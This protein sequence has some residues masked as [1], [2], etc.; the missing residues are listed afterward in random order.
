MT[1]AD[2]SPH[3][4]DLRVGA[5]IRSRR[6]A[7]GITQQGLAAALGISFQQIQKYETGL[8]RISASRL[9]DV[10]R[11]LHAPIGYFFD[12][13]ALG[14]GADAGPQDQPITPLRLSRDVSDMAGALS[15]VVDDAV[16][17]GLINLICAVGEDEMA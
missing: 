17:R 8:N 10:A 12:G 5:H 4:I 3:P 7:M 13:P 16:R 1:V 6:I 9:Y 15:L 2:R 11:T 14:S